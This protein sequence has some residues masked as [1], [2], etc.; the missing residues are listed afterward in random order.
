MLFPSVALAQT[1][2]S[3]KNTAMKRLILLL[4]CIL[5]LG[6]TQ[7]EGHANAEWIPENSDV[8]KG[9]V[10]RTVIR[11]NVDEGWHTYWENPGEVGI[12]IS[13]KASL[14]EGW[15]V[16]DVQYPVPH[17]IT[18]SDLTSFC[19]EG[20]ILL[21]VTLTPH[22]SF[23]GKLPELRATLSWLACN[24]ESCVSGKQEVALRSEPDPKMAT[25]AYNNLP[26]PM[27]GARLTISEDDTALRLEL[28]LPADWKTDISGFSVFPI[29][30]NVVAPGADF[31]FN[32][33]TE[34]GSVWTASAPKSEYFE[35]LPESFSILVSDSSGPAW[36]ISSA[37]EPSQP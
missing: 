17:R 14:P 8:A 18:T 2:F 21:P 5:P 12:P 30:G 26:H 3:I 13:I 10:V 19:L 29:T 1:Y 37:A 27:P 20:E 31:K 33:T 16:G 35:K 32:R 25:K 6:K 28:K 11:M 34:N 7:G 23:T 4:V 9:G 36:V 22:S 24:D 15:V